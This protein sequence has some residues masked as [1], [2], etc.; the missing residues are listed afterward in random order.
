MGD[1]SDHPDNVVV[2]FGIVEPHLDDNGDCMCECSNCTSCNN[3]CICLGCAN[4]DCGLP[5]E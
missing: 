2:P 5:H 4:Y 1:E 3:T